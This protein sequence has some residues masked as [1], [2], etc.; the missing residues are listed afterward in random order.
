MF[1]VKLSFPKK[2]KQTN[3][4]NCWKLERFWLAKS[5]NAV[6]LHFMLFKLWFHICWLLA[7]C[8]QYIKPQDKIKRMRLCI[9]RLKLYQYQGPD[10]GKCRPGAS[11]KVPPPKPSVKAKSSLWGRNCFL[12]MYYQ[13][14]VNFESFAEV[15]FRDILLTGMGH[16]DSPGQ[17]GTYGKSNLNQNLKPKPR[18]ISWKVHSWKTICYPLFSP[19]VLP[20]ENCRPGAL[21]PLS[22]PWSIPCVN[23]KQDQHR[24]WYIKTIS[25]TV[26][27]RK[28]CTKM[29]V[30]TISHCKM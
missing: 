4:A 23:R 16:R 25:V 26:M 8:N 7:V 5:R 3:K 15:K 9:F 28:H 14:G 6:F 27:P 13:A 2:R 30:F 19:E 18:F 12:T 20:P 29:L 22:G 1:T 24:A 10:M 21:P 11:R 17:I